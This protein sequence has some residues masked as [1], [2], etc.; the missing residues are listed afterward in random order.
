[1]SNT[2]NWSLPKEKALVSF[3]HNNCTEVEDNGSFKG[4]EFARAVKHVHKQCSGSMKDVKS[5]QNKW[6]S[7]C[8]TLC[9]VVTI[10]GVSGFHWNDENGVNIDASTA[11]I[12]KEYIKVHTK[13]KPFHNHRWASTAT[14]SKQSQA[15]DDN[16]TSD[17]D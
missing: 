1:M 4:P 12:W 14:T 5:I 17:S 7:L 8:K 6:Q 2:L 13:A 16:N 9:V 3:F 10:M 11:L 15:A